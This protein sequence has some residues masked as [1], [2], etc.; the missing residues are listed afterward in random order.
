MRLLKSFKYMYWSKINKNITINISLKN[1]M[2]AIHFLQYVTYQFDNLQWDCISKK[3]LQA[4][5]NI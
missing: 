3:R 1:I 4:N 2:F 5:I